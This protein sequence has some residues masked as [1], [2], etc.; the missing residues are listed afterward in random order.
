M[1]VRVHVTR[2]RSQAI[3]LKFLRRLLAIF[4]EIYALDATG[5]DMFAY[6][7]ELRGWPDRHAADWGNNYGSYRQDLWYCALARSKLD[8]RYNVQPCNRLA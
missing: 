4:D 5:N 8:V 6:V 3:D 1:L 7:N 2:V